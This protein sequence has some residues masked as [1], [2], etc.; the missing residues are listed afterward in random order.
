MSKTGTFRRTCFSGTFVELDG[1]PK[2]KLHICGI[3][4]GIYDYRDGDRVTVQYLYADD[5]AIKYNMEKLNE[6]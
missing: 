2:V 6:E 1:P 4:K 5:E 3:N